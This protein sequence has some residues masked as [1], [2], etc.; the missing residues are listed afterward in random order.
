MSQSDEILRHL[1]EYGWITPMNA[2]SLYGC[3]RLAARIEELRRM[4]YPIQTVD[5]SNN[6]KRYA[7]YTLEQ[8]ALL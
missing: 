7:K 5:M 2:L 3:F 6:G 8:L 1:Q 4:G